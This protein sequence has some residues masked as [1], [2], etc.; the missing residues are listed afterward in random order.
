MILIHTDPL[1]PIVQATVT[2]P[3]PANFHGAQL[4]KSDINIRAAIAPR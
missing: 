3:L 2:P 4:L 1:F